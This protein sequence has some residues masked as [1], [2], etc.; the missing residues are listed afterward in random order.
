LPTAFDPPVVEFRGVTKRFRLQE[1]NTLKEFL[2]SFL[3]GGGFFEPFCALNEISFSVRKGETLGIIGRNG[4]GKSTL[5]KLIAGVMEPTDGEVRVRGRVC[6]LLELGAGFNPELTGRENVYLGSSLLGLRNADIRARF[7][8]IVDFAELKSFMDTPMKRYSS[9]MFVRLTFSVAIHCDPDVL[10]VDEALSVGDAAF[11]QK[12]IRRMQDFQRQGVTIVLVSHNLATIE[13][14]C[15]R[16]LVLEAG[17]PVDDGDPAD[18]VA[19]Y[20]G[21]VLAESGAPPAGLQATVAI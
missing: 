12:C 11:Q 6:P 2:P 9:G 20:R 4:S 14:F 13:S 1:A 21:L 18:V 15:S 8:D 5:L 7:D 16:V 10:L 3:K 17:V 19:R